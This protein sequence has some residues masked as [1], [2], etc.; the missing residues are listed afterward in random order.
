MFRALSL[1]QI[2]GSVCAPL[3]KGMADRLH[4]ARGDRVLATEIEGASC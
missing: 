2:G 4:L 1:L 3:P